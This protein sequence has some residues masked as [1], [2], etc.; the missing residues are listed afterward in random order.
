PRR[1]GRRCESRAIARSNCPRPVPWPRGRPAWAFGCARWCR[2]NPTRSSKRP[3]PSSTIETKDTQAGSSGSVKRWSMDWKAT[4]HIGECSR[5]GRTRGDH[6]ARDHAMGGKETYGPWGIV[7]AESAELTITLGSSSKTSDF[8][9]DVL[10]AKG[11]ALDEAERAPTS[12]LQSNMDNGRERSGRRTQFLPRMVQ[13]ADAI[14]KPMP[15]L[16][17]S[18][19]PHTH[20]TLARRR[21]ICALS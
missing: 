17:Y 15:L 6:P 21:G 12:L 20:N 8:I 11:D 18:P 10:E 16:Y 9:V 7:D 5:G 2:P 1:Q 14:H 4:V 13:L 3:T 19:Y